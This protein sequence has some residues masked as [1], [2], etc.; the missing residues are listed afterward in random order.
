MNT[1]SVFV[2]DD[3]SL[4]WGADNDLVHYTPPADLV[5]PQFSPQVFISAFSWDGS[6]PRMAETIATL[7][8]GSKAVA[9]IGSL[10]FDRRNA[11][12]VRYRILPEQSSWRESSSLD[13]PIG[14]LSSGTHTLEAQ[15]R[16]FTGPWSATVSRPL[17]VL[18]PLG[19]PGPFCFSTRLRAA[20]SEAA[21]IS[22]T[23]GAR[24]RTRN[25]CPA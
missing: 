18:R 25:C 11:L 4:W 3:G 5:T 17:T 19:F 2:D 6:S 15:G 23:G 24:P 9:H 7:P 1:C 21:A 8:H 16:V 22:S 20:R 13:L 12:R 10:Q 14:S